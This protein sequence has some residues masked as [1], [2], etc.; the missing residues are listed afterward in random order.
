MEEEL[1][2]GVAVWPH[3]S[4]PGEPDLTLVSAG[5]IPAREAST[6]AQRIRAQRPRVHL[7]YVHVNDLTVL[8]DPSV[9][10]LGLHQRDLHETLGEQAPVLLAVPFRPKAARGLL[11]HRPNAYR[12]HVRGYR[13]PGQPLSTNR[14][15]RHCGMDAGSISAYALHLLSQPHEQLPEHRQEVTPA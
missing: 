3:L 14:L 12:F 9:W 15:L 1:R 5:D 4:D 2:R 13:D 6:A 10:P 8:G 7:R 11:F